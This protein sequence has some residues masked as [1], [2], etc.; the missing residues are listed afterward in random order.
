MRYD[1]LREHIEYYR[2]GLYSTNEFRN[3]AKK[4]LLSDRE[5]SKVVGSIFNSEL[6]DINELQLEQRKY[7]PEYPYGN[8][9]E[10]YDIEREKVGI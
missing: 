8:M 2:R 5:V 1:L 4:I 10:P 3:I 9:V 7:T 6:H